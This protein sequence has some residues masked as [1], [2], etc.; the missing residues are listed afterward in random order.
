MVA[1]SGWQVST[2]SDAAMHFDEFARGLF[3][4]SELHSKLSVVSLEFAVCI[5]EYLART[6]QGRK[7]IVQT[8]T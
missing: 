7:I 8:I 6:V 1:S 5:T 2:S 4:M 3:S